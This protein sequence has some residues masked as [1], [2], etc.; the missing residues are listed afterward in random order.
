MNVSQN[1]PPANL[2]PEG[3]VRGLLIIGFVVSVAAVTR[4]PRSYVS[5][6]ADWLV[7]VGMGVVFLVGAVM[8]RRRPDHYIPIGVWTKPTIS[9]TDEKLGRT[10]V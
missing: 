3:I 5:G 1:S 2:P 7:A 4:V 8:R 6:Y 9:M 10:A